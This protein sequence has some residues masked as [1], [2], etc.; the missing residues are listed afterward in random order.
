MGPDEVPIG[1]VEARRP[2]GAGDDFLAPPEVVLV[3]AAAAGTI[4]ENQR[5]LAA[6]PGASAALSIACGRRRYVAHVNELQVANVNAKFHG[7]AA[8]QCPQ[9][10]VTKRRLTLFPFLIVDLR[11]VFGGFHIAQG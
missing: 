3:M 5:R 11:G 10:S 8:K 1:E 7:G 2:N 9:G 4:G 6:S